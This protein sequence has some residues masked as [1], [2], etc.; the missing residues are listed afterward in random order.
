MCHILP[1][2][3]ASWSVR[4]E[5]KPVHQM[6]ATCGKYRNHLV[7]TRVIK[8]HSNLRHLCTTIDIH[9]HNRGSFKLS[10]SYCDSSSAYL[11]HA[12]GIFRL[13]CNYWPN[14]INLVFSIPIVQRKNVLDAVV[15]LTCQR[16]YFFFSTV[17]FLGATPWK[18][19]L[20]MGSVLVSEFILTGIIILHGRR[21]ERWYAFN[22][23]PRTTV[24]DCHSPVVS[25]G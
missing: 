25:F 23:F 15:P 19:T 3:N 18:L 10:R 17:L 22:W 11:P 14:Y 5:R 8:N 6:V 9:G 4:L 2:S 13:V 7:Y 20:S 24:D 16:N 1:L 12:S 21:W